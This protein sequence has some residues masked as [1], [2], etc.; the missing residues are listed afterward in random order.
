MS[1]EFVIEKGLPIPS[2]KSKFRG[3][4][5]GFSRAIISMEPGDS[6][7]IGCNQGIASSR[8]VSAVRTHNLSG[9][10]RTQRVEGGTRIWRLE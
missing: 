10:F 3:A 7:F 1:N 8:L 2:G 4:R 5:S 9:K 6:F